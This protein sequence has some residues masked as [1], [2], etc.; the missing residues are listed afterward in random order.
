[1]PLCLAV[2]RKVA[3]SDWDLNIF[4]GLVL[5]DGIRAGSNALAVRQ[6]LGRYKSYSMG[7]G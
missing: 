7:N 1:M 4:C 2:L 3:R 5:L 6:C